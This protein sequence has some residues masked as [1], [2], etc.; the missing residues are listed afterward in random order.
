ML[1]V[2]AGHGFRAEQEEPKPFTFM[3]EKKHSANCRT[4][5]EGKLSCSLTLFKKKFSG[6]KIISVTFSWCKVN[7]VIKMQKPGQV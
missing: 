2:V 7:P 4:P 5:P 1:K 3:A 6:G